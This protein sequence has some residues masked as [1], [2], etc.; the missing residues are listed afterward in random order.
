METRG[1][2]GAGTT[3]RKGGHWAIPKLVAQE[4]LTEEEIKDTSLSG[5]LD[6]LYA[7]GLIRLSEKGAGPRIKFRERQGARVRT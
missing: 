5:T 3:P 2:P 6:L 4:F 1:S 7:R